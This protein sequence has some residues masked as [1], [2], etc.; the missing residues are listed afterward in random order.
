MKINNSISV[1]E[2]MAGRIRWL[3]NQLRQDRASD[4]FAGS[5]SAFTQRTPDLNFRQEYHLR[6]SMS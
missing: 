1:P 6:N 2:M 4:V 3:F 5:K